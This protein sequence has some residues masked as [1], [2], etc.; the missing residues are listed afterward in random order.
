M[1]IH[2]T[3]Y[4][5]RDLSRSHKEFIEQRGSA[6]DPDNPF[7]KDTVAIAKAVQILERFEHLKEQIKDMKSK[8]N[9]AK[10]TEVN[11]ELTHAVGYLSAIAEIERLIAAVEK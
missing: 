5:L 11:L 7:Y 4:Q 2:E 1:T 6:P 10:L 8:D 9:V 3:I